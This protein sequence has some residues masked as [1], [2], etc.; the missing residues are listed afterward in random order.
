M[1]I[2]LVSAGEV[3][4]YQSREVQDAVRRPFADAAGVSLSDV[5]LRITGASVELSIDIRVPTR[6]QAESLANGLAPRF[7]SASSA[8]DFLNGALNVERVVSQPAA[9]TTTE[10]VP[11]PS[12]PPLSTGAGMDLSTGSGTSAQTAD[13]ATSL[14]TAQNLVIVGVG[15]GGALLGLLVLLFFVSRC[16]KGRGRGRTRLPERSV[17]MPSF[18]L[19]AVPSQRAMAA[20]HASAQA[21]QLQLHDWGGF[22]VAEDLENKEYI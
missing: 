5:R 21:P 12:A 13:G 8:R 6:G 14:Y 22:V 10:L 17:A 1:S 2:S 3:S 9:L 16:K 11:A 20:D 4:D 7:A 15:A 18:D 19:R